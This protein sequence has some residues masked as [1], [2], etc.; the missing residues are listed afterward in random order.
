MLRL[1]RFQMYSTFVSGSS[2]HKVGGHALLPT[3]CRLSTVHM[4]TNV[5]L[6]SNR[7]SGD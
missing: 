7:S 2:T 6:L 1:C 5:R 4:N 3:Q